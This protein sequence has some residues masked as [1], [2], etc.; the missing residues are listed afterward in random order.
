MENAVS[1]AEPEVEVKP[2]GYTLY[3]FNVN[4][5]YRMAEVGILSADDRVELLEGQIV[6]MSPI[7]NRHAGHL[8]RIADLLSPLV[9]H[10]AILRMQGPVRL[11]YRSEPQPDLTLLKRRDDFYT[12]GHPGAADVLLIVEVADTSTRSDREQKV[13][14]Y[15]RFGIPEVWLVDINAGAVEVYREPA[16]DGYRSKE[17][18]RREDTLDITAIPGVTLNIDD[19]LG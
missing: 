8:D 13:P 16:A 3:R 7:G 10:Q 2:A 9:R 18:R 12:N 6:A 19:V 11:S 5:Y 4:E 14:L 1:T 17:V 15:A